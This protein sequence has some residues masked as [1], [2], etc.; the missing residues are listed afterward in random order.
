MV[1]SWRRGSLLLEMRQ[2]ELLYGQAKDEAGSILLK[3]RLDRK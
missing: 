1:Q 2:M 3:K